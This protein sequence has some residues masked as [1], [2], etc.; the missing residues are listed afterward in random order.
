MAKRGKSTKVVEDWRTLA[1]AELRGKPVTSLD[2]TTPE[3][4]RVTPLYT[5]EDLEVVAYSGL[6]LR[7]MWPGF[8]P[9][10]RGPRATMYASAP[11]SPWR[12][13]A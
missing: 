8:S 5:A 1:G 9:Y 11:S 12:I 13:T 6:G 2:W 10:L 3:G 4:I 7:D